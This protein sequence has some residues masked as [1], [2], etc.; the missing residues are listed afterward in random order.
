METT[1]TFTTEALETIDK[2]ETQCRLMAAYLGENDPYVVQAS[3]SLRRSL[4]QMVALRPTRVMKDGEH[5]LYCV[6]DYITFGVNFHNRPPSGDKYQG[7]TLD[8][9]NTVG[10][11]SINS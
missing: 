10:T 5:S 8:V 7:L 2:M 3:N 6:S 4:T 11:W 9:A 1:I